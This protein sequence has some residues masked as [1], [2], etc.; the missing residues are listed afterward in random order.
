MSSQCA[1]RFRKTSFSTYLIAISILTCW[2]LVGFLILQNHYSGEQ[3]WT[4]N[5]FTEYNQVSQFTSPGH[6]PG[7]LKNQTERRPLIITKQDLETFQYSTFI[8]NVSKGRLDSSKRYT[9]HDFVVNRTDCS[10]SSYSD[11][12]CLATQGS[13]DRLYW[14][15]DVAGAWEGDISVS[16]FVPD[17]EFSVAKVYISFLRHCFVNVKCHVSFHIVYPTHMPPLI[18]SDAPTLNK[19]TCKAYKEVLEGL[20]K[21]RPDK[22]VKWRNKLLYPQNHMRNVA[23][24]GCHTDYHLLTDID[25]LPVPGLAGDLQ[26]FLKK[27]NRTSSNKIAYVLPTYEVSATV[28]LPTNKQTILQ[29]VSK[30]QARPFHQVVFVHNQYATNHSLWEKLPESKVLRAAY[31]IT[32]YEFFYE[33]FYVSKMDIPRHD[34]RFIGYGFT[35]NTQVFEMIMAGYQFQVLD[36]VFAVHCGLQTRRGRSVWRERQNVIN[37]KLFLRFKKDI[38]RKYSKQP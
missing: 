22:F 8:F 21:E 28:S 4:F 3:R 26:K 23:R 38:I 15:V 35:R 30:G 11:S 2:N 10:H 25:I 9:I 37:R 19:L 34:E 14:L 6:Q 31:P 36:P 18:T 13:V 17:V 5:F 27:Q 33:P 1:Q 12:I 32:K 29:L 7:L 20:L 24:D 16:V